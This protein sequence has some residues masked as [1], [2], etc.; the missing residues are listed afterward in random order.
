MWYRQ[1]IVESLML[2]VPAAA[3]GLALTIATARVFPA[4]I[5]ATFPDGI[6]PVETVLVPL[7]PDWRVLSVLF[8]AAVVSAVIVEP[9]ARSEGHARESRARRKR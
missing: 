6:A 2:A 1:L 5:L 4:L 8:I 9:G 3:V 7:D